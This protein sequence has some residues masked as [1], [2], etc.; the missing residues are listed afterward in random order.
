MQVHSKRLV[1]E[2]F[3]LPVGAN[4]GD[5]VL[6]HRTNGTFRNVT[7]VAGTLWVELTHTLTIREL[8]SLSI[9]ESRPSRLIWETSSQI[10]LR[11][12]AIRELGAL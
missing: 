6:P 11:M 7:I 4:R 2:G 9:K 1:G 8:A 10:V 5:H 3:L 12:A